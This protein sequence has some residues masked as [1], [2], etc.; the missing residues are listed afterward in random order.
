LAYSTIELEVR[1][2]DH[3]AV[4]TRLWAEN[5]PDKRVGEN[6]VARMQWLYHDNP[7]GPPRT[8]LA[9]HVEKNEFIGC[10]STLRRRMWAFGEMV[11][12]GM[13][14]DF[15]VAKSHRVGGAAI[16][17]QRALNDTSDAAGFS[18]LIGSPNRKSIPIVKRVG[19]QVIGDV[20]TWV[21]P[22][23]SAY[24]LATYLKSKLLAKLAG[25]LLDVV[26]R[27]IDR[28]RVPPGKG[29][30]GA[31]IERADERFDAL[32]ERARAR[33]SLIGDKTAA[34]LNWRYGQFT[35]QHFQT[36][37]LTTKDGELAGW[38]IFEVK[39]G[40][41]FVADLFSEDLGPT[42]DQLLMAFAREMRRRGYISIFL[43]YVGTTLFGERLK[44]VG[45][46]RSADLKRSLV[47][48]F[49]KEAP[50]PPA[51]ALLNRD[52]WLMFDGDMDI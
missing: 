16:G 42:V 11:V 41:V 48:F 23:R 6:A 43:N 8:L 46:I 45:F 52:S 21:K 26:F 40:K 27:L 28:V 1:N 31:V 38:V 51:E 19:Y 50:H 3:R 36:F 33:F 44:R 2:A 37:A 32:W 24:K 39:Q 10:G 14:C 29:W 15:A 20:S 5:L 35:T 18:F 13:P 9:I 4:L 47:V 7:S 49:K 22:L 34:F 17:I 25:P 12:T 30:T